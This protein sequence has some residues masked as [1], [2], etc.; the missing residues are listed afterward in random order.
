MSTQLQEI[1]TFVESVVT[2]DVESG[3]ALR[4]IVAYLAQLEAALQAQQTP[5]QPQPQAPAKS[6]KGDTIN[7]N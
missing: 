1:L 5:A 6:S 4:A 7:A 2:K 3:R